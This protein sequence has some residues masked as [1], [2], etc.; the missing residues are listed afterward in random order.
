MAF[1]TNMN[2]PYPPTLSQWKSLVVA[3]TWGWGDWACA[4]IPSCW[5][6]ISLGP[7]VNTGNLLPLALS[8]YPYPFPTQIPGPV[9]NLSEKAKIP[10]QKVNISLIICDKIGVTPGLKSTSLIA[11]CSH[12]WQP[13]HNPHQVGEATGIQTQK[14]L[15]SPFSHK[16]S[17]WPPSNHTSK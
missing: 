17:L 13:N 1:P 6:E 8:L 15:L 11:T 2:G 10:R 12:T 7:C 9:Q 14:T 3:P 16:V 5:A 4:N